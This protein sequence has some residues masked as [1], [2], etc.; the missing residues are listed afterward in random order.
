MRDLIETIERVL[1]KYPLCDRCLGRLFGL[2]GR[3]LSN[4]ERGRSL[5]TA[6]L[7]SIL[8]RE[9]REAPGLVERLR[10]LAQNSGEPFTTYLKML[11]NIDTEPLRCHVC[12]SRIEEYIE[13]Y[14][15]RITEIL[16]RE[17]LRRFLLGVRVPREVLE[18]EEA[19]AREFGIETWESIKREL[20]REIGKR[21]RDRGYEPD[22]EDPEVVLTID[23][24]TG[25]VTLHYPSVLYMVRVWKRERGY[26]VRGAR[27]SLEDIL[28]ERLSLYQPAYVRIHLMARDS[29]RYRIVGEG[30]VAV[31][32]I[33]SPRRGRPSI[34]ELRE[35]VGD[36]GP[37]E[38]EYVS[39]VDRTDIHEI[40]NRFSRVVYI[41]RVSSDRDIERG[42]V[43]RAVDMYRNA[44]PVVQ[45]TPSRLVSRGV[46]ETIRRGV[47][48]ILDYEIVSPREAVFRLSMDRR[49]YVEEF[50]S[51]DGGRTEPSLSSILGC[52]LEAVEI[53]IAGHS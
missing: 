45:K 31:L 20:K 24:G 16:G 35:V 42:A 19:L 3:G 52:G 34:R 4:R 25:A 21:V 9:G 2:L 6:L 15:S 27:G 47:V 12:G 36:T 51:G 1:E 13:E 53:D 43:E 37:F 48:S 50:V 22:F 30:V 7:L 28:G 38:I 18:R 11:Y 26:L 8:Y 23:L 40:E 10:V 17:G 5:K 14:S 49:L 32:E 33:H 44:I 41:V 46:P 29:R 39:R